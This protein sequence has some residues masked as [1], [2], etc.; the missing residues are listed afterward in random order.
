MKVDI[1][2]EVVLWNYFI[3]YTAFRELGPINF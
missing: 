2:F 3:L 1:K